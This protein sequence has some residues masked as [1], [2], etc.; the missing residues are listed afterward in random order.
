MKK[1]I[2]LV[3]CGGT[4]GF[5]AEGLCRLLINYPEMELLFIDH[6]RVE[7]HNLL[8][9]H[10]FAEDIGKF[11]SQALAER[12]ARQY[13]RAIQYS[14]YP[15]MREMFD[16]NLGGGLHST[17]LYGLIISC[18]DDST[19]ARREIAD[20]LFTNTWWI[21]AGNGYSSGQVLIGNTRSFTAL[22][23]AFDEKSGTVSALPY[24]PIQLSGLLA[25]APEKLQPGRDCAE[26]VIAEEQSP[27]IN[28][29]M[30]VLVLEFVEKLLNGNL[31]SMGAYI[32]LEAGTL[33]KVPAK[34]ATVARMLGVSVK[35]L[36]SK[37][38]GRE[39]KLFAYQ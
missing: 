32:D 18:V 29:A 13:H 36:K 7:E 16:E 17:V 21:D 30:A 39:G 12:L 28:Q 27:I 9:Q 37:R 34:P 25:P 5:V 11:K 35:D 6:D 24:P 31:S 22:T 1:R 20:S 4:G 38:K 14:V 26:A 19:S 10:F 33:Y 23:G 8:R 2:A 15:F 3:G